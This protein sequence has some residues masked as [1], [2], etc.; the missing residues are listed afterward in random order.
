MIN[1]Y[2]NLK[3]CVFLMKNYDIK[4]FLL[5]IFINVI[6]SRLSF[7]VIISFFNMKDRDHYLIKGVFNVIT[8]NIKFFFF[9]IKIL[10]MYFVIR[11]V[12]RIIE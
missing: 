9:F 10:I 7:D 3:I 2:L 6:I 8:I 5:F 12:I 11:N 4:I 1:T